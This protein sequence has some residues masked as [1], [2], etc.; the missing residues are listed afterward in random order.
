MLASTDPRR[1]HRFAAK[2][3]TKDKEV[4]MA[5]VQANGKVLACAAKET[6]KDKE[7]VMAAIQALSAMI[8]RRHLCYRRLGLHNGLSHHVQATSL[9]SIKALASFCTT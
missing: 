4:V 6:K 7:V 5:A 2:E 9:P 3:M 8:G 1:R